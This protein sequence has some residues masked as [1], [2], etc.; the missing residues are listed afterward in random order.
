M[1]KSTMRTFTRLRS[2]VMIA[3]V[4][5][6]AVP[7]RAIVRGPDAGGYSAT[8]ATVYS[9]V[10]VSSAGGAAVLA[11]TDDGVAALTL[12]FPFTFYGQSYSLACVSSNGALYFI[13]AAASCSGVN[14]IGNVDLA[15]TTPNDWPALFPFWSDLTFQAPGAG[16]VFYQTGGAAGNR[17]CVV[18]WNN[19]M[20]VES[21]NP[22]TFE[23]VLSEGTNAVL[24]QY[25]T[26]LLGAGNPASGGAEATVGVRNTAGG[27]ANQQIEWSFNAP[28]LHDSSALLFSRSATPTVTVSNA[29]VTFD[30]NP[31]VVTATAA[32]INNEPLGPVTLTYNGSATAPTTAGT[33]AVVASFAGNGTYAAA[34]ATATLTISQATSAITWPAPAPITAGTALS[35]TQLDA[36]ASTAGM[37]AYNPPAGTVLGVG[38]QLLT[39]TFTPADA[40]DYT[41]ATASVTLTV[42]PGTSTT[43]TVTFTGA[44]ATAPYGSSFAV[45][46]TTNASTPA[47]ITATGSCTVAGTTVTM[48]DGIGKCSLTATWA[49]DGTY[50]AAS[51]HQ[52]T[53]ATKATPTV[54]FTGAPASALV[55]SSFTVSATTNAST[56][57]SIAVVG[58]NSAC[59]IAGTTV[60]MTS[61]VGSCHLRATWAADSHYHAATRTQVTKAEKRAPVVTWATPGAIV[62]GA[63]LDATQL[64][65]TADG[66]GTF[67]YA[68]AA[69]RILPGGTHTLSVTFTPADGA[70]YATE[71]ATVTLTVNPASPTLTW[72]APAAITYGTALG[73]KQLDAKASV[74]GTFAYSPAAGTVLAVGVHTLS[75]VF[76][77]ANAA[78]YA[79]ASASVALTVVQATP[80]I[81]WHVPAAITYGTAL[82]A[83]QLDAT[84]SVAGAF[85]YTPAAGTLLS[86]GSHTL[87]VTFTPADPNYTAAAKTV[88]ITVKRAAR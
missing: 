27:A 38:A 77:P 54:A 52:F 80:K 39:A 47:V 16:A 58:A 56:P 46:A 82:D 45:T 81:D 84:A 64:N 61:G 62:Y 51:A 85:A 19:A 50:A 43:P 3:L 78:N 34:S 60:T 33:Y 88:N 65:A 73:G 6:A 74:G 21:A 63:A 37:F 29:T 71:K 23:I 49:A 28:V 67:V 35:A 48:T 40:T 13:T 20:P 9:F 4:A 11:G 70:S 22:V 14:D 53:H 68:P 8:D 2:A 75:V 69:G 87:S 32:G 44:P 15:L 26:V 41:P 86:V 10:D 76:T 17:R 1:V 72:N 5:L 12:P 79:S 57:V 24:F 66:P 36:S 59:T 7:L 55:G 18:Q 42:N 31:H 30:G 25:K 83:A